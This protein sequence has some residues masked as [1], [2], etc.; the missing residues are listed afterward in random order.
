MN[1][2]DDSPTATCPRCHNRVVWLL[3]ALASIE[4]DLMRMGACECFRTAHV[5][6]ERDP[7]V[8]VRAMYQIGEKPYR[9]SVREKY[10]LEGK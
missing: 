2:S 6:D 5:W 3:I 9:E 7:A 10:K 4:G 1:P 8:A